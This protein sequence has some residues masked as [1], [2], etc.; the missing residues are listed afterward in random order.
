MK[1]LHI[2]LPL[3]ALLGSVSN[4]TLSQETSEES[5]LS[6]V[7]ETNVELANSQK[8][9]NQLSNTTAKLLQEYRDILQQKDYQQYYNFQ[10]KQTYEAQQQE[11]AAL[12]EQLQQLEYI[13]VAIMPLMQSML[14]ALEEFVVLDIPFHLQTR[15]DGLSKLRGRI[16]SG[17]LSLPEKYRLLM[18]VWQIEHDY[19]R[20][21]ETWRG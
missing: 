6:V 20:S 19:G 17:A 15:M 13:E 5:A 11:I 16:K 10:L 7:S 8:T 14:V 2:F 3:L 12:Q 4:D 21:I 1:K 9:I 18:E